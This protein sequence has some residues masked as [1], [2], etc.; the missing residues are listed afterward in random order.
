MESAGKA[1]RNAGSIRKGSDITVEPPGE[2]LQNLITLNGITLLDL[3]M[4]VSRSLTTPARF[5]S[6][7]HT[8]A[9]YTL[10]HPPPATITVVAVSAALWKNDRGVCIEGS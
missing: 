9:A 5:L 4:G 3:W 7:P 10:Q 6:L 1:V 8:R 2:C